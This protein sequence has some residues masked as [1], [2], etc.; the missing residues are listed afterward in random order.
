MAEHPDRFHISATGLSINYMPQY[1]ASALGYFQEVGLEV[2]SYVPSPWTVVLKDVNSGQAQAVVGGIWVPLS[3]KGRGREY[4]QF[5][6]VSSR[7]PMALLSREPMEGEFSFSWLEGKT[8][9]APGSNSIGPAVIIAGAAEE[10]GADDSKIDIVHDFYGDMLEELF[11]G[12]M[13]DVLC[14]KS[15]TAAMME[16]AGQGQVI[17]YLAQSGGICPWS[18]YY[19]TPET[20][21]REDDLCGRFT[22]ALQRAQTWLREHDG[23]ACREVLAANWPK[24]DQKIA[25]QTVDLYLSSGMWPETVELQRDEL[26]RWEDMLIR[27]AHIFRERIPYERIVD[28]RPF[29]YARQRLEK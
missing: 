23:Y 21:A 20:L 24:V 11:V 25:Q 10:S 14:T 3:Y 15:E 26:D 18:V 9:L 22:L 17:T 4:F 8:V 27:K 7:A 28:S 5:A 13:G 6:K 2:T 29:Q 1:L 19:A 16:A 12:G